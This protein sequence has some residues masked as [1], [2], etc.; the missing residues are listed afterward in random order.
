MR[1][2]DSIPDG[3][4]ILNTT[5]VRFNLHYTTALPVTHPAPESGRYDHQIQTKFHAPP[6]NAN[7]DESA[8]PFCELAILRLFP[9]VVCVCAYI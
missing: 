2:S 4:S 1:P 7:D 5:L 6:G 9:V 3:S 8:G